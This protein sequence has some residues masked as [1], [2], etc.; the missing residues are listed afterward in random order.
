VEI[1]KED[2]RGGAAH[3]R[4]GMGRVEDGLGDVQCGLGLDCDGGRQ[5]H[6]WTALAEERGSMQP[7]P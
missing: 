7:G 4:R 5:K 2:P 6:T 3:R 1:E